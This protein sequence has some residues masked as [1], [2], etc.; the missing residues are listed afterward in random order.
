MRMRQDQGRLL[1]VLSCLQGYPAEGGI[2]NRLEQ[3]WRALQASTPCKWCGQRWWRD[4]KSG[5]CYRCLS[6]HGRIKPLDR[7]FVSEGVGN[8]P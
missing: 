1:Q 2:M 3:A 6:K 5:I 7:D 8:A 4:E